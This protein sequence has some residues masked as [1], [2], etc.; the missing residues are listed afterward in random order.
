MHACMQE[1]MYTHTH[2][3]PFQAQAAAGGLGV[4]QQELMRQQQAKLA[5]MQQMQIRAAAIAAAQVAAE[6]PEP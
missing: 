2:Y 3:I 6:K 5:Q 4:A 1:L